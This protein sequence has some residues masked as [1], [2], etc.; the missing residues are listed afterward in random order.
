MFL[1]KR[2]LFLLISICFIFFFLTY[3]D[4]KSEEIKI[5]SGIA[6]VTDGDTIKINKKKIRLM[7]IDAPEKK[8]KC[9]QIWLSI[10][11]ISFEKEYLCGEISTNKLKN[12]IDGKDIICKYTNKDIYKRFI[13]ECFKD[14]TNIN[15]WMVRNG[16]AVAFR[17]Y[18]KKFV[19]QENI[20]KKNKSGLWSG[21]FEM[22]WDWRKKNK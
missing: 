19:V 16:H 18:S 7:G 11:F 17:K 9:K 8:Q 21:T 13:A 14:K 20:A 10:S 1:N 2:K 5:I 3:N 15:S 4:L 12:L 22:P 6:K